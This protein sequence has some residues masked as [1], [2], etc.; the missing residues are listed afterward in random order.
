MKREG[1][2]KEIKLPTTSQLEQELNRERHKFKYKKLLKSTI[3][4]LIIVVA[5]SVLVATFFFPVFKIYGNS[6]APT[7]NEGDILVSVK[8]SKLESGDVI[9]FY[10]NNRILVKRVIATSSQ[11]VDIDDEGNVFVDNEL[12]EEPYI[13]S[14]SYGEVD[15]SFPYQVPEGSYFVLGDQR[16]VSVD[17]RSSLIGSVSQEEIIGKIIFKVWPIKRF[18]RIR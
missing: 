18:G 2:F 10:Y 17:S 4:T 1:N 16:E 9:A 6:M 7:F 14:K 5:L 15:I 8:D 12:L 3:Y 13:K 11:W